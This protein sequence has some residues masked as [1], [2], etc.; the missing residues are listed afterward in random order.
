MLRA[1][2]EGMMKVKKTR[3]S[4]SF[5]ESASPALEKRCQDVECELA[6]KCDQISHLQQELA[7]ADST[8]EQERKDYSSGG[9]DYPAKSRR[10]EKELHETKKKLMKVTDA[11]SKLSLKMAENRSISAHESPMP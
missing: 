10:L 11:F 5:N 1:A 3:A 2:M 7:I 9:T 8:N 4:A 6:D